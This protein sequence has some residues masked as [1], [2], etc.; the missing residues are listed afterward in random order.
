MYILYTTKKLPKKRTYT[1]VTLIKQA[2]NWFRDPERHQLS[3]TMTGL[4]A[5]TGLRLD[6]VT[7]FITGSLNLYDCLAG[8]NGPLYAE[9]SG[10]VLC[11]LCKVIFLAAAIR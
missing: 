6:S 1:H 7:G 10:T 3:Y 11:D 8:I 9:I 2:S 4:P 5:R